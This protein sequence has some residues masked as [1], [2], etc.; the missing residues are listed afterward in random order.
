MRP[1]IS[2]SVYSSY[3][4]L[5]R[6]TAPSDRTAPKFGTH[7]RIVS[8][9]L[10]KIDPPHP[11]GWLCGWQLYTFHLLISGHDRRTEPKFGSHVRI[12]TPTLNKKLTHPTPGGG[13]RGLYI[14][15]NLSRRIASKFGTHV[16]IDTLTLKKIKILTH[17]TPGGLGGYI[18]LK[19]FR[20]GS[21]P[22]LARMCG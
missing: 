1:F 4:I 14:V 10:K 9:T 13:F 3:Y 5:D 22:N 15:K 8:L 2:A 12:D 21:R 11:G 20:D 17:P 18:L 19:I 7:V 16:R 6:R